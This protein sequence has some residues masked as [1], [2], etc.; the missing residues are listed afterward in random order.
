MDTPKHLKA[1]GLL[2]GFDDSE[3]SSVNA[4]MKMALEK[5]GR[6][7]PPSRRRVALLA[8]YG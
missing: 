6:T 1:I 5:V 3:E 8:E 4:L 2:S 7:Y